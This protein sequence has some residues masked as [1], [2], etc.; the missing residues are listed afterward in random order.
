MKTEHCDILIVGGGPAGSSAAYAAADCGMHVI[1]VDKRKV[2]G[3]PVQCAEYIPAQLAGE[4][5]IE[6]QA[7]SQP[8]KAMRT[9]LPDGSEHVNKA[10]GFIIHRDR[11]DQMLVRHASKKGVKYLME[12]FAHAVG[13]DGVSIRDGKGGHHRILPRVIIGADGPRSMVGK[14]MGS[15]VENNVYSMQ[16]RVE[17]LKPMDETEVYFDKKFFG[18]YGW[19]F[20]KKGKANA[21]IGIRPQLIKNESVSHLLDY[22][23][24]NLKTQGKITGKSEN[25]A[26]GLIPVKPLKKVV[27]DNMLLAGDAAG[28]AHPITGA[29]VSNAVISGR[30]AGECAAHA[31]AM[32]SI[33]LL[34]NY[35]TELHQDLGRGLRKAESRRVRMENKWHGTD[36]E[37]SSVIRT[38]WP[39][40]REYYASK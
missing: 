30:L 33:N 9:Y 23:L 17:L 1:V 14:W 18:G 11:F 38:S 28:L 20:P 36:E 7:I 2:I 13:K 22:F 39:G 34:K 12:T 25:L 6:R 27:K 35:E 29:G 19:L 16:A 3:S 21:G 31:L 10:P 24:E 37:F 40:F 4:I 5:T 32:G 26:G 15:V 8:V